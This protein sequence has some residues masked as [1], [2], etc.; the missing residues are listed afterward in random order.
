[1]DSIKE[2][3]DALNSRI[4]SPIFGSIALAF[5]AINW[6][7]LYFL[8][9]ANTTATAR[10]AYFETHTSF[11]SAIVFPIV[12]GTLFAIATPWIALFSTWVAERPTIRRKIRQAQAAEN[13]LRNKLHF[14]QAREAFQSQQEGAKIEAAKRDEK[15]REISDPEIRADLQRQIDELRDKA[16]PDNTSIENSIDPEAVDRNKKIE[17]I[18]ETIK[19]LQEEQEFCRGT[20]NWDRVQEIDQEIS[21]AYQMRHDVLKSSSSGKNIFKRKSV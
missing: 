2:I 16:G 8:V 3:F 6:K 9:F 20:E 13:L 7:S 19:S 12:I 1:M 11:W 5:I 4:R 21:D 14:E 18:N 17:N 15:V 10:I